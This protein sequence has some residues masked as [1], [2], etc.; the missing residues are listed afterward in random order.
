MGSVFDTSDFRKGLK[1]E[2]RGDPWVI[3]DFQPFNPGKGAAFTR[4]KMRNLKSGQVVEHNIRSGEKVE[5]ADTEEKQMQY[6]YRDGEGFHF[7]DTASYEQIS[8]SESEVGDVTNFLLE[9]MNLQVLFY[10]GKPLT[11]EPPTFV[12]L[13]VKETQPGIK[14]D[15]VS[16]GTK[17]A[18]LETGLVVNVPFHINE[19]DILRIDTRESKYVDRVKSK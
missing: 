14:G 12:E 10:Q 7:M 11:V 18:T 17:P 1:I 13:S 9:N 15:T 4:T 16:G 2:F 5:K 8:L 6:L 19:G 3:V